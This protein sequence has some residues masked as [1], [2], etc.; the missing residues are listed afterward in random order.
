V[1]GNTSNNSHSATV[2][3]LPADLV[4]VK[5][6]TPTL[7]VDPGGTITYTLT[8]SNA[9][10][11]LATGVFITDVVPISVTVKDVISTNVILTYTATP[12][13][14]TW[15]VRDL[16]F[17][18]GGV[19]TITGV[20]SEPLA[21]STFPNTATISTLST[22]SD[23]T[24]NDSSA[25]VTVSNVAPVAEDDTFTT[26]KDSS[27]H[28]S[29]S[30][31][32]A[33]GDPLTFGI[34]T[35]PI[36]GDVA[37]TDTA[38]GGFVYTPTESAAPYTDTFTFVV[39]D[40]GN[41][42]DTAIITVVV[43]ADAP[44][45]LVIVKTV[46]PHTPVNPGGTIAY[47]LTFSNAGPGPATGVVI[48]DTIPHGVTSTRVISSSDVAITPVGGTRYV[49]EVADLPPDAGGVITI[50]GVL[51]DSLAAGVFTNTAEIAATSVDSDPDN[52]RDSVSVTVVLPIGGHT[53]PLRPLASWL[54]LWLAAMV[55][56]G[57]SIVVQ[58]LTGRKQL[59]RK[60]KTL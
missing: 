53:E 31:D 6:V 25:N 44:V 51:S 54:W 29:L 41:L 35:N 32:D 13:T 30:A 14:H 60:R 18:D 33:N 50:T 40:T 5:T 20:L 24:D 22:D 48:S 26:D 15:E 27:I 21:A 56:A 7:P 10:E 1:D 28:D 39:T 2:A 58:S 45:D 38:T 55:A 11:G 8:F 17:K 59:T 43:S 36:T 52:N 19:I 9:G 57:A 49:W 42:T 34:F 3:I 4:I 46:V 47:V 37:I 23:T 16:V 12:P